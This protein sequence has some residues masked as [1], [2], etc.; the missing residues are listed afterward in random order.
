MVK[1]ITLKKIFYV[2]LLTTTQAHGLTLTRAIVSSDTNPLYLE[3]WPLVART[4]KQIVGVQPT[5]LLIAPSDVVV[6]TTVGDVIR[7]EPIPGISTPFQAQ[8]IRLLAPMLFPDDVCIISDIDMIPLTKNYFTDSLTDCPEDAFVVYRNNAAN[9]LIY[10]MCYNAAKG[11]VFAEVF[12]VHTVDDIYRTMQA[13]YALG[14]GWSTDEQMLRKHVDAWHAKTGRVRKLSHEVTG[15]IDRYY[16]QYYPQL[17]K[18]GR[19]IDS[20]MLRPYHEYKNYIDE[21]V[22]YL[23]IQT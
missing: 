23:G 7:F 2:V 15:R 18:E 8:V 20:H 4:W 17:V 21:L 1:K 10:S 6:D 16:W 3:F 14:L 22:S 11:R 19:Y 9:P 13:W 12:N 5:L